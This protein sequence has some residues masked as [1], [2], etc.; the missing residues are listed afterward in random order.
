VRVGTKNPQLK[1]ELSQD[2]TGADRRARIALH[3]LAT[4]HHNPALIATVTGNS[5]QCIWGM[6][7]RLIHRSFSTSITAAR[8]PG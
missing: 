3:T 1:K 5:I 7:T 4:D 6:V 8:P 2:E